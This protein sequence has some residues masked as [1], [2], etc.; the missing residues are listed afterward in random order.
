VIH[1]VNQCRFGGDGESKLLL[2]LMR[3]ELFDGL[4]AL[5][6]SPSCCDIRQLL[7]DESHDTENDA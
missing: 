3:F 4:G 5:S 6:R 2:L 1:Q 7:L